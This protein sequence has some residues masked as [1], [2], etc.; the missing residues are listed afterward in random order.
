[1]K[2]NTDASDACKIYNLLREAHKS[3]KQIWRQ[4][5]GL[6]SILQGQYAEKPNWENAVDAVDQTLYLAE[7]F[8][9]RAEQDAYMRPRKR[10]REKVAA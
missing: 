8:F 4:F 6:N 3:I 9:V 2:K 10:K 7:G 5:P 1:M